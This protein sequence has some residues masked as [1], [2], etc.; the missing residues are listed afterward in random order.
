M[1]LIISLS[2]RGGPKKIPHP[3]TTVV[4][5]RMSMG[6]RLG[7]WEPTYFDRVAT[8]ILTNEYVAFSTEQARSQQV[9]YTVRFSWYL[10]TVS[11]S[12]SSGEW[13]C[14][15]IVSIKYIKSIHLFNE[16]SL[17]VYSMPGSVLG[18]RDEVLNETVMIP[19]PW[20][21]N[22]YIYKGAQRGIH[23]IGVCMWVSRMTS[24]RKELAS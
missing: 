2:S 5:S 23:S 14:W 21:F 1:K 20:C 15:Q 24:R 11:S 8:R 17:R 4:A 12:Q 3:L 9:I 13:G 19:S 18:A 22:I 6:S 7:Q 10:P 16:Y